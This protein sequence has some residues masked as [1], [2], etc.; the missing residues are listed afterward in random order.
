V[1]CEPLQNDSTKILYPVIIVEVVSKSSVV[2]DRRA[3]FSVYAKIPSL[4]YYIIVEQVEPLVEFWSRPPSDN[5]DTW[6]AR[7]VNDLGGNLFFPEFKMTLS[8]AEI[9]ERV[10][11]AN[12]G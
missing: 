2:R 10:F 1:T 9:Y 12:P 6:I 3:K 7:R 5:D 8:M 4:K 11:D